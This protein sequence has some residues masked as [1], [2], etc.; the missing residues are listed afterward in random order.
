[1]GAPFL[2]TPWQ[3]VC[4]AVKAAWALDSIYFDDP[5]VTGNAAPPYA[6]VTLD[7]VDYAS[8]GSSPTIA[9]YIYS[10]TIMGRFPYPSVSTDLIAA[11]QLAKLNTIHEYLISPSRATAVAI[12]GIADTVLVNNASFSSLNNPAARDYELVLTFGCGVAGPRV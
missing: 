8:E 1:M 2:I 12:R 9:R 11:A 4:D 7:S 3:Y 6:I 5:R 10:F